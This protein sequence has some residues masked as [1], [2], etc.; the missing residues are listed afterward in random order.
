MVTR[1][2]YNLN[3]MNG[4]VGITLKNKDGKLQV[5]FIDTNP[6]HISTP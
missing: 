1:N 3:L 5:A 6:R 2:D 4:D